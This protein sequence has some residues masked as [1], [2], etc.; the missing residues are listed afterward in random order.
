MAAVTEGRV[1]EL[2]GQLIAQHRE[3]LTV[4]E[5]RVHGQLSQLEANST[6]YLKM[7]TDH[8]QK[9]QVEVARASTQQR[10]S[11]MVLVTASQP[12]I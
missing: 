1:L 2:F 7:I 5:G 3:A 9:A 10:S 4:L 6:Q 11:F 12:G 8:V